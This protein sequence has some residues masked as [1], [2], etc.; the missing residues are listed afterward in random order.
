[1]PKYSI[2]MS[3]VRLPWLPRLVNRKGKEVICPSI[4]AFI[5]LPRSALSFNVNGYTFKGGNSGN[6]VL[7][8]F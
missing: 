2:V 1:M 8:L 4:F 5:S 6:I 7:T 3:G